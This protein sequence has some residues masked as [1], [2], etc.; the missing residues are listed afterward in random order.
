MKAGTPAEL[1]S[2][3]RNF[4]TA[5]RRG[6]FSKLMPW[7]VNGWGRLSSRE[8]HS[9]SVASTLSLC[10]HCRRPSHNLWSW[11]RGGEFHSSDCFTVMRKLAIWLAQ[12]Q[13]RLK[14]ACWS[15]N[16]GSTASFIVSSRTL[17]RTLPGADTSM[18]HRKLLQSLRSPF[19][20]AWR[21]FLLSTGPVSPPSPRSCWRG[22]W[23]C[24][25]LSLCLL[26]WP[27]LVSH[28]VLQP[29]YSSESWWPGS[30]PTRKKWHQS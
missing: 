1:Q 5:G 29:S 14:P 12:D 3:P 30:K 8:L 20:T 4:Q 26:W 19:L 9:V 23:A 27:L 25:Q 10:L 21:W 17:L 13:F 6:Q 24:W 2:S 28:P 22:C 16:L 11:C 18:L 7:K 15:R